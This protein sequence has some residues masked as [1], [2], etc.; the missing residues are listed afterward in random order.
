[1]ED[2][3]PAEPFD[4]FFYDGDHAEAPTRDAILGAALHIM[5]PEFILVVDDWN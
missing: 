2:I 5:A 4:V 3:K 1:M